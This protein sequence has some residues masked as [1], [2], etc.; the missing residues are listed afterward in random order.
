MP[1][2]VRFNSTSR[3][4]FDPT[5]ET[6]NNVMSTVDK[7]ESSRS[8][9]IDKSGVVS[10]SEINNL[11]AS[12]G[13][14]VFNEETGK[15]E[16]WNGFEWSVSAGELN[17]STRLISNR[18]SNIFADGARGKLDPNGLSGWNFNNDYQGEKINWYYVYNRNQD[19]LMTLESLTSMYAVVT[20]YNEREFHFSVYTKRQNDGNDYSW[21]RSRVNYELTTAF[22]GLSGQTVLVYFGEEPTSFSDLK[23]VELPYDVTF[24]NGLQAN[25]EEVLFAALST[26]SNAQAGEYDF[27][28]QNLGY[29]NNLREVNS[30][31]KIG[32]DFDLIDTEISTLKS[33]KEA[34]ELG[35][36]FRGFVADEDGM[37]ALPTPLRFEYIARMDTATIWEYN[38]SDWYDTLIVA[39][40]EGIAQEEE[41]VVLYS[42]TRYIDLDG[43]NDYVNVTG[44]PTDVMGYAKEWSLSIQLAGA[45]SPIND[46]TYITLFKRGTNEITLRRGGSNWGLYAWINGYS[47]ASAQANTWYAPTANSTILIISTTT[48]LKYYLDGVLR[49]NVAWQGATHLSSQDY[50][51]DLQIGNS[52]H[53]ANWYG[54]VN[55]L[56]V[57][58][59]GSSD[60][61]KDQLAEFNAQ[62]NVSNMSFYPSVTDFL[63]L[64]ERPYPS[65]LGMKQVLEGTIENSTESAIAV[66]NP[67]GAIGTPFPQ[68]SGRYVFLDGTDN[69]IEFDNANA[70][71]LDFTGGKKWA[72]GFKCNGVSGIVD[73]VA[74]TLWRRGDNEITLK[75]GG[76]NWGLYVYCDG[77]SIGQANTWY[78]PQDD[79]TIVF[80]FDGTKLRYYID[81]ALRSTLSINTSHPSHDASGNLFFGSTI[82]S[83]H[84][85]WYGGAEN[86]FIM[87]GNSSVL[88]SHQINEF[89][90]VDGVS[91]SYYNSLQDYFNIGI[92][93]Y[94]SIDGIKG[95]VTGN[96]VNGNAEDFINI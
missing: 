57:M 11:S 17:V 21:Y 37:N 75:R 50:S 71:V 66:K 64:G 81:G 12:V 35:R 93:T 10:Q 18:D 55:N 56:M 74:T 96:L 58:E 5:D 90:S 19:D 32:R 3:S 28:V 46:S 61:G 83:T 13:D 34:V 62:D 39:S 22:D 25:S 84:A 95:I 9:I 33:F 92:D 24:S 79:S 87:N 69:Y 27:T 48:H 91:L 31:L 53:R 51:G 41:L 30:V 23:R 52:E 85:N 16:T 6:I 1:E 40:L 43:L 94:P 67:A 82:K 36:F 89:G 47:R 60:L 77:A 72:V 4:S 20:I 44:V 14:S 63:C 59:G 86:C 26:D 65:V 78:A 70:D 7:R 42:N 88:S 73:Y 29:I 49:A 2:N 80:T 54:G 45:V 76:S 38:G 68:R 8:S 15:I